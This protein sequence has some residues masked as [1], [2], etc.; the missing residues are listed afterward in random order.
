[1]KAIKVLVVGMGA[2]ILVGLALLGYGL[3]RN[4][5]APASTTARS[6]VTGG[7]AVPFSGTP[8]VP[9]AGPTGY[10][11]SEVPVPPGTHLDQV[12]TAG[13][14]V[15]LHFSGAAGQDDRF[16]M[17]DPRTG[18]VA[19]TVTLVPVDQHPSPHP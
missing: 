19:G 4:T 18:Q 15:I 6:G 10:F 7:P 1:M 8:D 11:T 12:L 14:R 9:A 17:L 13:D 3:Y 5:R 16:L 2:L